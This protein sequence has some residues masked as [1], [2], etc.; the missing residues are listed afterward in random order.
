MNK[1]R[2]RFWL[3]LIKSGKWK[4]NKG[5]CLK[6]EEGMSPAGILTW[7]L[8]KTEF[9]GKVKEIVENKTFSFYDD[10]GERRVNYLLPCIE[11]WLDHFDWSIGT[12]SKDVVI[13]RLEK[14]L[15]E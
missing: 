4:I 9:S 13:K 2:I 10:S 5:T 14:L 6:D 8:S 11:E 3:K 7:L 1:D 12:A 15:K